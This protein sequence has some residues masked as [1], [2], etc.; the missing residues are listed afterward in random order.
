MHTRILLNVGSRGPAP[1]A[2][3]PKQ[4]TTRQQV[5]VEHHVVRLLDRAACVD[6]YNARS[7]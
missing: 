5:H 4:A 2:K 7:L 6:L 3:V 1:N